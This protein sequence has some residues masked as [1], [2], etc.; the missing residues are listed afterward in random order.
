MKK[1][2][3]LMG[4]YQTTDKQQVRHAIDSV[5]CQT[6]EDIELVI[7]DDGSKDDTFTFLTDYVGGNPKC[8]LIRNA[9]NKGL[10]ATLNYCLQVSTGQFIARQDADD[11]AA[12]DKLERQVKF[13]EG[14]PEF[15]MVGTSVTLFDESGN[16]ALRMC[17]PFPEKIHFVSGTQFVHAT[18]MIRRE[19]LEGVGGYRV[20]PETRYRAQDRDL[21]MRMYAAGYR[22]S[23]MQDALYFVREDKQ[24]YKRRKF[25]HQMS[26][27]RIQLFGFRVMNMPFWAYFFILKTVLVAVIPNG[28]MRFIRMQIYRVRFR[29]MSM[30]TAGTTK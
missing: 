22:G 2:S 23:N 4:V 16:Y 28:L 25:K 15:D 24:A 12:P 9:E 11:Y 6:W 3:I 10:A 18:I 5:L 26:I 8:K 17:R 7:C 21:F 1:V 20:A 29:E 27:V 13:L 14:N 30:T 19:A